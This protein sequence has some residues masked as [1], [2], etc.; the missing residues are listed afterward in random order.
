[1]LYAMIG[2]YIIPKAVLL[3]EIDVETSI[4]GSKENRRFVLQ[5]L[6]REGE[7][8]KVFERIEDG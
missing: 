1:M 4:H 5:A 3:A 6:V 2:Q 7:A 8:D